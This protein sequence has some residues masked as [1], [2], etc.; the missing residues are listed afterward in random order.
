MRKLGTKF[1][2]ATR[3]LHDQNEELH[4][5]IVR[6][7]N[8]ADAQVTGMLTAGIGMIYFLNRLA[9]KTDLY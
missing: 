3:R 4:C 2:R 1:P 8:Y 6:S 7:R 5:W 9:C